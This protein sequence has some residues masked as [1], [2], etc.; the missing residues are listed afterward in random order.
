[1]RRPLV[2]RLNVAKFECSTRKSQ[3]GADRCGNQRRGHTVGMDDPGQ[4]VILNGAPRSGKTSICRALQERGP[5]V[6]VNLGVD[7][8]VKS[9]PPQ[10]FPGMG[11]RPGGERPDLENLVLLSYTAL[12]ESVA[13]H[14]RLGFH[15]VVDVG[16]HE[17][18]SKPLHVRRRCAQRLEGLPV[19]CVGVHC[20]TELIWRRREQTWG[21]PLRT[22]SSELRDAVERWQKAVHANMSYDLELDTSCL[23]PGQ[24]AD[25]IATRLHDGPPGEAFH[26]LANSSL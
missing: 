17:S 21:Q 16:L 18:Y 3:P 19:L 25:L 1:M 22:A 20:P 8:S 10:F 7:S 26:E 13:I 9:I 24:C 15:V 11:L 5:G 12:Y 23:T 4:I 6:W 2:H 14:A